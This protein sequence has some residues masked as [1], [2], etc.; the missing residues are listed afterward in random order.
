M[1]I[2]ATACIVIRP[3]WQSPRRPATLPRAKTWGRRMSDTAIHAP[4]HAAHHRAAHSGRPNLDG[5]TH[6][7]AIVIFFALLVIGLG[8]TLHGLTT[9]IDAAGTPP[10][11]IGVF[12]MLGLALLIALGFE[13]VNGFHDTANADATVIYT[14]SLQPQVAVSGPGCSISWAC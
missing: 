3:K 6:Y 4:H 13:F 5:G 7:A 1:K 9:D 12:I 8:F 2:D 10:L 11:A 14:H